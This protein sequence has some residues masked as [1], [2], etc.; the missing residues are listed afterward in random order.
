MKALFRTDLPSGLPAFPV[1]AL[2]LILLTAA[3]QKAGEEESAPVQ[4][5]LCTEEFTVSHALGSASMGPDAVL[6][7]I[8]E[9]T[10]TGA[11]FLDLRELLQEMKS[12]GELGSLSLEEIKLALTDSSA[13]LFTLEEGGKLRIKDQFAFLT[14]IQEGRRKVK[15]SLDGSKSERCLAISFEGILYADAFT[16]LDDQNFTLP[17]WVIENRIYKKA[18]SGGVPHNYMGRV[19]AFAAN[20]DAS[21]HFEILSVE[22]VFLSD[23]PPEE[24]EILRMGEAWKSLFVLDPATGTLSVTDHVGRL[25]ALFEIAD[26]D[27]SRYH[28]SALA[29]YP[30]AGLPLPDKFLLKV[31]VSHDESRGREELE[32]E[33]EARVPAFGSPDCTRSDWD[34]DAG[35]WRAEERRR[36]QS[37][38]CRHIDY[39]IRPMGKE[40]ITTQTDL[41][42]L[43]AGLSQPKENYQIIFRDE[44]SEMG[45]PEKLDHRLWSIDVGMPCNRIR[46]QEGALHFRVGSDCT[47]ERYVSVARVE[48]RPKLEYRY[49][50]VEAKFLDLPTGSP[51]RAGS[52]GWN[53]FGRR[54]RTDLSGFAEGKDYRSFL[55]RG[56]SAA[57][58]R[59][60]WLDTFGIEMQYLEL[61]NEFYDAYS[62]TW[63]VFHLQNTSDA[64]SCHDDPKI[65]SGLWWN[66]YYFKPEDFSNGGSIT[67]GVEWTPSG[68][69]GFVDGRAYTG[70]EGYSPPSYRVYGYSRPGGSAVYYYGY[71]PFPASKLLNS[72]ISHNY[73]N[74]KF[75][76]KSY[77]VGNSE[78]LP[79]GWEE[80]AKIDYIRVFQ[81]KDKYAS[82]TKSYD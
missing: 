13:E 65:F 9:A 45:G 2:T 35:S 72:T 23:P 14:A 42:N 73:Q 52:F 29:L 5:E 10:K 79:E 70:Y 74:M 81:P 27:V 41:D 77:P 49:G 69:R 25:E 51:A 48:L 15:L 37:A 36:H 6:V 63:W 67:I 58:K 33:I 80:S 7:D 40:F 39:E 21:L 61:N 57:R 68:Y 53:S 16:V 31:K 50:Y 64:K 8:E 47:P 4:Q 44:F 78:D 82:F 12:R 1:L 43:P 26:F 56:G 30:K 55:C 59:A 71:L 11:L 28:L 32:V 76:L 19:L 18:L 66:T 3:C 24:D 54:A 75:N 20:P 60:R 62:T 38:S 46:T 34:A 22:P 17:Y